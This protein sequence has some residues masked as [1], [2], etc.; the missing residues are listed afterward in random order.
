MRDTSY[1]D[2]SAIVEFMYKGEINVAQV[3]IA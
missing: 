3:K 2:I 1:A